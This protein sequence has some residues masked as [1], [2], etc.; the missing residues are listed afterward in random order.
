[1]SIIPAEQKKRARPDRRQDVWEDP[2]QKED[3][4]QYRAKTQRKT[5][6]DPDDSTVV[7]RFSAGVKEGERIAARLGRPHVEES[8]VLSHRARQR[9]DP[10][11]AQPEMTD[12][13]R[14]RKQIE[15]AVA[16]SGK[17]CEVA[18]TLSD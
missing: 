5:D 6:A 18:P 9:P 17:I 3:R 14:G 15:T 2:H 7:L 10:E 8:G 12:D 11:V 1:M 13:V 4:A 16:I